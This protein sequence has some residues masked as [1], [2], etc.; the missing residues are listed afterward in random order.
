MRL[1]LGSILLTPD[2][3]ADIPG[4]LAA[5]D[6][7]LEKHRRIYL[8]IKDLYDRGETIDR[9]TVANE[10]MKH[11]QLESIDGRSY[12]VSLDEGLPEIVNLDSYIRILKDKALLRDTMFA[13]QRVIDQCATA[14]ESSIDILESAAQM[15]EGIRG[16]SEARNQQWGTPQ[17]TNASRLSTS[18]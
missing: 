17:S 15:L 12:L 14:S 7:S 11:G 18:I 2:H 9:V 5:G 16:T 4:E 1:V 10:L 8:R 13:C 6:F 3:Y